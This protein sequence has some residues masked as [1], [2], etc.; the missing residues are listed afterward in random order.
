MTDVLQYSSGAASRTKRTL[1]LISLPSIVGCIVC[2]LALLGLRVVQQFEGGIVL[3]HRD[4]GPLYML[5]LSDGPSVF[6][7]LCTL[8]SVALFIACAVR[9]RIPLRHLSLLGA[10]IGVWVIGCVVLGLASLDAFP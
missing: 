6:F 10:V 9:K 7:T 4:R 1:L 5:V 8:I 3:S 2:V